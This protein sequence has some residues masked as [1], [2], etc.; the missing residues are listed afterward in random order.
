MV[1]CR[2]H[3]RD[4]ADLAPSRAPA[5]HHTHERLWRSL[6]YETE[7]LHEIRDGVE[8]RHGPVMVYDSYPLSILRGCAVPL[9]TRNPS[10]E[11]DP[12][13]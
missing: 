6:K 11:A 3:G 1:A 5:A 9:T 8:A 12:A 7:Y 2:F 10:T 13:Q 4:F